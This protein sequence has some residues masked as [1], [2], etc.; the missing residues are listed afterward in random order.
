MMES[1]GSE[2]EAGEGVRFGALLVKPSRLAFGKILF[3]SLSESFR[4]WILAS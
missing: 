1:R 3:F 4:R 2:S